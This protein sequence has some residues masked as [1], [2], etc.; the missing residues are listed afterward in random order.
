MVHRQGILKLLGRHVVHSAQD[1]A[2]LRQLNRLSGGAQQFGHA[3]VGDLHLALLVQQNIFRL[4]VPVDDPLA[5]RVLQRVANLRHDG[6]NL[7][8]GQTVGLQHL[9][10]THAVHKLHQEVIKLARLTQV[11]HIHDVW[12]VQSGQ[13]ARFTSKSL[14]EG[15][16]AGELRR[17]N[18]QRDQ[19]VQA[20]LARPVNRTHAA[21]AQQ[22]KNLELWEEAPE[23]IRMRR[24]KGSGRAPGQ[25]LGHHQGPRLEALWTERLRPLR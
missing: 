22:A 13:G 17:Q 7:P 10:Q 9:P 18:L 2:G 20:S 21:G 24:G 15:R 16:V 1:M 25:R 19:P 8:G 6:Q 23:R 4:D 11:I 3:E 14:G 5:V 12:V